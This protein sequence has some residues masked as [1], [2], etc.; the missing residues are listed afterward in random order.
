MPASTS[1]EEEACA[2]QTWHE[3]HEDSQS[4]DGLAKVFPDRRHAGA[5]IACLL[6]TA[7]METCA[8]FFLLTT[9]APVRDGPVARRSALEMDGAAPQ[10][11]QE[12]RAEPEEVL[13]RR[14]PA[15][16]LARLA[17]EYIFFVSRM[18]ATLGNVSSVVSRS[19]RAATPSKAGVELDGG[20]ERCDRVECRRAR[21]EGPARG[22]P[23]VPLAQGQPWSPPLRAG[24]GD[25]A[26]KSCLGAGTWTGRVQRRG[27]VTN[28]RTPSSSRGE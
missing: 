25:S 28:K 3:L 12:V 20:C 8:R 18:L 10:S 13:A 11:R 22:R 6:S 4:E 17:R 14:D 9:G 21:L 19:G 15:L 5:E 1:P 2:I 23:E 7:Q 26:A 27:A 16:D 24:G